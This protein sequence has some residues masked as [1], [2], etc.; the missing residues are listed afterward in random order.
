[1]G[2]TELR[3][4][5]EWC[6]SGNLTSAIL[7]LGYVILALA[8]IWLI[9]YVSANLLFPKS[10]E[11]LNSDASPLLAS[12]YWSWLEVLPWRFLNH[13]GRIFKR[14]TF[15][16]FIRGFILVIDLG[17]IICM[18]FPHSIPIYQ[19]KTGFAVVGYSDDASSQSNYG[20]RERT[21]L[22]VEHVNAVSYTHLT[23]PTTSRV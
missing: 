19:Q 23:L 15:A 14:P 17:I 13:R 20:A 10:D 22:T 18:S 6:Y 4:G 8:I 1:M 16:L 11:V 5:P 3:N 9:E 7:A 12:D 2:L 21:N